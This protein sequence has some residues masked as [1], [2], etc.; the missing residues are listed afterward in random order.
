M[1]ILTNFP[2]SGKLLIDRGVGCLA[3]LWKYFFRNLRK[4]LQ[5]ICVFWYIKK[6]FLSKKISIE[7]YQFSSKTQNWP[8]SKTWYLALICP[9]NFFQVDYCSE[10][11]PKQVP[12]VWKKSIFFPYTVEKNRPIYS[13]NRKVRI[14]A[15]ILTFQIFLRFEMWEF[16]ILSFGPCNSIDQIW[17]FWNSHMSNLRKILEVRIST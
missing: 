17:E 2:F 11:L 4:I 10:W 3:S 7:K 13:L 9:K 14:Y 12:K 5:K 8:F 15:D 6:I 1:S 16:K